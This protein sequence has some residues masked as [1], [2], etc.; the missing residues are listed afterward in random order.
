MAGEDLTVDRLETPGAVLTLG[1]LAVRALQQHGVVA[2]FVNAEGKIELCPPGELE[3][4]GLDEAAAIEQ[5]TERGY[6]KPQMID[7]L[8]GRDA[9]VAAATKLRKVGSGG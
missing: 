3:L 1:T 8:K 2:M 9:R 7:Y 6:S 4:D 5:L